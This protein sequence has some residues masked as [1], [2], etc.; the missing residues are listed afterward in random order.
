[1]F[2]KYGACGEIILGADRFRTEPSLR[3]IDFGRNELEGRNN[4]NAID[5]FQLS[6]LNGRFA[7][8]SDLMFLPNEIWFEDFENR[9]DLKV[10]S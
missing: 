2:D 5:S 3:R 8:L 6:R 9:V 1:M 10:K 7:L 4:S